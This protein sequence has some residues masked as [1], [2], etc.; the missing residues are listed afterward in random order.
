MCDNSLVTFV[1]WSLTREFP[2]FRVSLCPAF[3]ISPSSGEDCERT[4]ALDL[5]ALPVDDLTGDDGAPAALG[6]YLDRDAPSDAAWAMILASWMMSCAISER[7]SWKR[8]GFDARAEASPGRA[9]GAPRLC[10]DVVG[11]HIKSMGRRKGAPDVRPPRRGLPTRSSPSCRR[12]PGASA[13]GAILPRRMNQAWT[14]TDQVRF[15]KLEGD[16]I[17]ISSAPSNERSRSSHRVSTCSKP[18][19]ICPLTGP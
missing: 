18:K 7:S 15:Y 13:Q 14:G 2:H 11:L 10:G 16:K 17:T 12:I 4:P 1:A 8:C 19:V 9:R 6:A 5:H 3:G